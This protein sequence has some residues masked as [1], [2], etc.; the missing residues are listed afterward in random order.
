MKNE[1]ILLILTKN[2]NYGKISLFMFYN[3]WCEKFGKGVIV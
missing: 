1:H 2:K 3:G